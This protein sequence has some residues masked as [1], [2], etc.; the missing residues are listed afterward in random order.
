MRIGGFHIW[1]AVFCLAVS[2]CDFLA[3]PDDNSRQ[4]QGIY[5]TVTDSSGDPIDS[6]GVH[7]RMEFN[8]QSSMPAQ[9]TGYHIQA[10]ADSIVPVNP[11]SEFDLDQNYP[12]PFNPLTSIPFALGEESPVLLTVKEWWNSTLVRT[13]VDTTLPVGFHT[14]L[15][16]GKNDDGEYVSSN[17]Y[18]YQITAGSY[19]DDKVMCL[20]MMDPGHIQRLNCIPPAMTD[21]HGKATLDYDVLPVWQSTNRTDADGSS[22]GTITVSGAMDFILLKA[23]YEPLIESVS[24]NTAKILDI[25]ATMMPSSAE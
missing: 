15:W 17:F 21:Q 7:M 9:E 5:F 12:N 14:V 25:D 18:D 8:F 16:D 10:G 11:P 20:H 4:T 19:T 24:I 6:V 2:Q 1:G 3:D 22:L 13:L 23:G